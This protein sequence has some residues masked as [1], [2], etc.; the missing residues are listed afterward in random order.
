MALNLT[1]GWSAASLV[2]N[3]SQAPAPNS[4]IDSGSSAIL[5]SILS[6]ILGAGGGG[7]QPQS[8]Q[9]QNTAAAGYAGNLAT[10]SMVAA[11]PLSL[12]AQLFGKGIGDPGGL[13]GS[14]SRSP[15]ILNSLAFSGLIGGVTPNQSTSVWGAA[16]LSS[17]EQTISQQYQLASGLLGGTNNALSA[18]ATAAAGSPTYAP[19]IQN[20]ISPSASTGYQYN[21]F[22]SSGWVSGFGTSINP[23]GTMGG[24]AAPSFGSASLANKLMSAGV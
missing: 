8:T 19:S 24:Y 21:P 6:S 1:Q 17:G 14:V 12:Y 5:N 20:S 11:S 15:N 3:I 16:P 22:G 4:T 13:I 23:Q 18:A 9:A 10:K 7:A 2:P